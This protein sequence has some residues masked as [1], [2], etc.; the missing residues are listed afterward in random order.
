MALLPRKLVPSL[1]FDT[2][3]GGHWSLAEQKPYPARGEA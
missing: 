1:E 3:G 2:V